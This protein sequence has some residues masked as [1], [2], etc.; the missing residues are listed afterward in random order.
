MDTRINV[1]VTK[2][3]T[4]CCQ[5]TGVHLT[6][7]NRLKQYTREHNEWIK[8]QPPGN[9]I[10]S[11]LPLWMRSLDSEGEEYFTASLRWLVSL[12]LCLCVVISFGWPFLSSLVAWVLGYLWCFVAWMSMFFFLFRQ[13][14][15]HVGLV[16]P[17]LENKLRDHPKKEV[18][19]IT[20]RFPGWS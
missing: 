8:I 19:V 1:I 13:L 18:Y 20:A 6:C 4:F 12:A 14:W 11:L 9:I 15:K 7:Q 16:I 5:S 17:F 3:W 10:S 2:F